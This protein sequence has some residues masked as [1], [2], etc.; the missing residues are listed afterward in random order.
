MTDTPTLVEF[1]IKLPQTTAVR[2]ATMAAR[3]GTTAQSVIAELAIRASEQLLIPKAARPQPASLRPRDSLSVSD[4]IAMLS[5]RFAGA[6]PTR[7]AETFHISVEDAE[8]HL[9]ALT[10]AESNPRRKRPRLSAV[11]PLTPNPSEVGTRWVA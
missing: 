7:I 9:R 11:E 10:N 6:S 4:G 1:T 3:R 2:Y 5:M 8:E